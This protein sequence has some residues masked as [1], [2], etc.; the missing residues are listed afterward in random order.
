MVCTIL[1][2]PSSEIGRRKEF[3]LSFKSIPFTTKS[4][5]VRPISYL[6]GELRII[7]EEGEVTQKTIMIYYLSQLFT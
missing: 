5:P 6:Y 3:V 1:G 4:L 7:W 2:Q